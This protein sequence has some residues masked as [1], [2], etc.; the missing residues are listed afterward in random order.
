MKTIF[1]LFILY[2]IYRIVKGF[3]LSKKLTGTSGI[4]FRV[5]V[6]GHERYS[7]NYKLNK[8]LS[9]GKP[10]KWYESGQSINVQGYNI[11]DGMIYVGETLLDSYGYEN[12]ACLINPQ[13]KV[14]PAEPWEA[15]YGLGYWLQ[16]G[17]ISAKC[18]GAYLKW[19]ANGRSEP[20]ANIGYVFLFFYGLERCF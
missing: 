20:K 14:S 5:G 17:S 1:I 2:V 15:G 10:A 19:L 9:D 12:D 6:S 7:G 4:T 16:Y 18:R 3:V 13:L 11:S 8:R